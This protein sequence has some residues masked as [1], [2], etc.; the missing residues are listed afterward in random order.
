MAGISAE[1]SQ[2]PSHSAIVN[3]ARTGGSIWL[4]CS[5]TR[6]WRSWTS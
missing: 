2:R 1:Q 4:H 6:F 3:T 5:V